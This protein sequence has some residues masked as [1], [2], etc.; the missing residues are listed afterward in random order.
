MFSA[1]IEIMRTE[2]LLLTKGE[3]KKETFQ[4]NRVV[5][6]KRRVTTKK[7]NEFPQA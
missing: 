4:R 7:Q 6:H 1:G 3:K 5:D 2:S